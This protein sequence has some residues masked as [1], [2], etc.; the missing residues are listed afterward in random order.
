MT[1]FKPILVPARFYNVTGEKEEEQS[2]QHICNYIN[3]NVYKNKKNEL[4]YITNKSNID[5]MLGLTDEISQKIGFS[6]EK[7]FI[8]SISKYVKPNKIYFIK[9][10]NNFVADEMLTIYQGGIHCASTEIPRGL[11]FKNDKNS[12]NK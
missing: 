6:F 4:V 10:D 9:G 3:A 8:N 5:S 1:G 2:L 7:S 12:R 11:N